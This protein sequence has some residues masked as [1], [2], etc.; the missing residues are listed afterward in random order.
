M[1]RTRACSI[2]SFQ[3]FG[4]AHSFPRFFQPCRRASPSAARAAFWALTPSA[5][6]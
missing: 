5:P 2:S 3:Q 4:Q 1:F 6:G